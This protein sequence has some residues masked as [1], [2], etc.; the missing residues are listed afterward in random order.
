MLSPNSLRIVNHVRVNYV[1][2]H[3]RETVS[4][5]AVQSC[6]ALVKGVDLV[7]RQYHVQFDLVQPSKYERV[8]M[9]IIQ[10]IPLFIRAPGWYERAPLGLRRD[11]SF[12]KYPI[13]NNTL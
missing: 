4:V 1:S 8:D 13:N 11:L 12:N 7:A 3:I 10:F 6:E 9:F 5:W 2:S